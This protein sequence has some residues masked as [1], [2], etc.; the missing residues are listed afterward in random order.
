M[1]Y[2]GAARTRRKWRILQAAKLKASRL[3]ARPDV[4][5]VGIGMRRCNGK[6]RDEACIVIK[7]AWKLPGA[8]L[9][10]RRRRPLPRWIDVEVERSAARVPVDV[11][12]T[13]GELV[14]SFQAK[15]GAP[16]RYG[17]NAI[18][19]VSAVVVVADTRA[20]LISGHVARHKGRRIEVGG[21][22][23]VTAEPVFSKRLDHCLVELDPHPDYDAILVDGTS[24]TGVRKVAA[25]QLGQTLYF[26]RMTTGERVPL[27]LRY[28]DITA[29]FQT[30]RGVVHMHGLLA[31]DGG[32]MRGDS[33]ALLY[34]E[35]F[36]AVGTLVGAFAG[37]SYFIPCDY[38]F[39]ALG[40]QLACK[41][42][43]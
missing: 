10:A 25:L 38:A 21:M 22:L 28:T 29:P 40:L 24:L 37:K 20:I 8:A 14:G 1:T 43:S 16:V 32:T 2:V 12:E 18:G 26:H 15:V 41:E 27:I 3:L 11:Q 31:T 34:D 6:W 13:A 17:E 35:T 5:A 19:S 36:R 30:E 23:G 4:L 7:V 33:G 39:A 42:P 9:R